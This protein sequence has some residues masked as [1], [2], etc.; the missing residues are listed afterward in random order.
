MGFSFRKW[1]LEVSFL[2][3]SFNLSH[4]L[5]LLF[6]QMEECFLWGFQI[7]MEPRG[8]NSFGWIFSTGWWV[9]I[10]MLIII[11]WPTSSIYSPLQIEIRTGKFYPFYISWYMFDS[12]QN[13]LIFN[14]L[15]N[16]FFGLVLFI[17]RQIIPWKSGRL[18][19][20]YFFIDHIFPINIYL[21]HHYY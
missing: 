6:L 14:R 5:A 18:F 16:S 13:G 17:C 3:F 11:Y 2:S 19:R 15:W 10:S 9:A 4:T 8:L 21:M 12:F 20:T 1:I 7:E